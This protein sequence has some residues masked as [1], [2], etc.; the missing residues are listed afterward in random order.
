MITRT[1]GWVAI[2]LSV[3]ILLI[4]AAI[5]LAA[6]AQDPP[7][8]DA[9]GI[10]YVQHPWVALLHMVP[11]LL[12]LTLAPLQFVARIRQ[13]R[14]GLHRGLGRALA[15]CAAISGLFALVASF[16]LPAFGGVS[17][18]TATVFFGA[19][20]IFSLAKA[21]RHI[22]RKDICLH[23][24]WMIRTFALATGVASIRV[25]IGLFTALSDLGLEEVFGASFWLGFGV[26]L[27]MAEVWINRTRGR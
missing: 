6:M 26:N 24:E 5:R 18:Q 15:T 19:I 25:F 21:I 20:F 22:R 8:T 10:R 2:V 13:R 11:G 16:R 7:P 4:F 1:A 3:I 14:I 12:F 27:L 17:T 9:F 23:R